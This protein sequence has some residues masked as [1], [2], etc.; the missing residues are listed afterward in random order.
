MN[1]IQIKREIVKPK[2]FNYMDISVIIKIYFSY[3]IEYARNISLISEF[4]KRNTSLL[5]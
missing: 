5:N 2:Y 1:I 4:R 3:F